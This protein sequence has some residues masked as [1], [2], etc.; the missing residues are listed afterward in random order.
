L[1]AGGVA[2]LFA[3][4]TPP[5]CTAS[6]DKDGDGFV[7]SGAFCTIAAGSTLQL[8]DCNDDDKT[9]HPGAPD[10]VGDLV[11]QNCDGVDGLVGEGEGEG[12]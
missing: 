8:N 4:C 9:I 7:A 12:E 6:D 5:P 10:S 1:C 3:A 2:L 11:D